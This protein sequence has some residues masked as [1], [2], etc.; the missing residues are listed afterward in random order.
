MKERSRIVF[1][2]MSFCVAFAWQ[3]EIYEKNQ[4]CGNT[5]RKHSDIIA[6]QE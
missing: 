3:F 5:I 2:M 4:N 6:M 1:I